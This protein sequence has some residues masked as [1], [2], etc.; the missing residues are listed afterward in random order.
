ME[1]KKKPRKTLLGC[2]E[3]KETKRNISRTLMNIIQMVCNVL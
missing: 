3:M 2:R 1:K